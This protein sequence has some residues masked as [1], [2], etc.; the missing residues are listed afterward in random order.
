MIGH[1]PACPCMTCVAWRSPRIVPP[2][3][4][5]N[6]KRDKAIYNSGFWSAASYAWIAPGAAE[7]D[8]HGWTP[9]IGACFFAWL[10]FQMISLRYME[11]A[12]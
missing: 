8:A 5:R 4:R 3:P 9:M 2:L 6:E 10:G 1:L 7:Y 11:K 12:Q